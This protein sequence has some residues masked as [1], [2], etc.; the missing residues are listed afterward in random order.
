[1]NSISQNLADQ[2]AKF[3]KSSRNKDAIRGR[4]QELIEKNGGQN[5]KEVSQVIR[6]MVYQIKT[7]KRSNI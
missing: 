7:Q 5:L 1:M 2:P 4:E 3:D 6:L